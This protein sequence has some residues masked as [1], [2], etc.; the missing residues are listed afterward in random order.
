MVVLKAAIL[1]IHF[2]STE[3]WDWCR[4]TSRTPH[5]LAP[6]QDNATRFIFI[7]SCAQKGGSPKGVFPP[8]VNF[9]PHS[10]PTSI[11]TL[12][13][14]DYCSAKLVSNIEYKRAQSAPATV[15]RGLPIIPLGALTAEPTSPRT[16]PLPAEETKTLHVIIRHSHSAKLV[17]EWL[18]MDKFLVVELTTPLQLDPLLYQCKWKAFEQARSWGV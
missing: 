9:S 6:N 2:R 8:F 7:N 13:L 11:R 15:Q 4:F 3:I 10:Q 18:A 14:R 17:L 12:T 16:D 1:A 5:L